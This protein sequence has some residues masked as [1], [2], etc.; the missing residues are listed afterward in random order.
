MRT[1]LDDLK[2]EERKVSA[3]LISLARDGKHRTAEYQK[4]ALRQ[5]ELKNLIYNLQWI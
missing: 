5:E 3:Q 4:L 2:A 1:Q